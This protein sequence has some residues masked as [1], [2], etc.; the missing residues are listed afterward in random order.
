MLQSV[1]VV[2]AILFA[3][4]APRRVNVS[5]VKSSPKNILFDFYLRYLSIKI[6]ML[7]L[8]KLIGLLLSNLYISFLH[9]RIK[10]KS[11]FLRIVRLEVPNL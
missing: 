11:V 8:K 7:T 10:M 3:L 4:S 6:C 9:T 2:D 1:D 5:S